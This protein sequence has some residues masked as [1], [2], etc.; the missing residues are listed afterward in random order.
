MNFEIDEQTKKMA[1]LVAVAIMILA[2]L[3]AYGHITQILSRLAKLEQRPTCLC[4]RYE[5]HKPVTEP[6]VQEPKVDQPEPKV[7]AT[8]EPHSVAPPKPQP[9]QKRRIKT[10]E[11]TE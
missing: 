6:K 5:Q 8:P 2:G 11:E 1:A 9:K 3:M 10:A 7:E 4:D